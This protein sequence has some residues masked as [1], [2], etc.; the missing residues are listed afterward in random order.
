MPFS[1]NS[2]ISGQISSSSLDL[3]ES[4]QP[5]TAHD[6]SKPNMASDQSIKVYFHAGVLQ[7]IPRRYAWKLVKIAWKGVKD[8]GQPDIKQMLMR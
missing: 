7:Q 4:I 6:D 3:Q 2:E 8:C 5:P 1:S